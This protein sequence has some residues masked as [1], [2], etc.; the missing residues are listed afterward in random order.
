MP[1]KGGRTET[2]K[3]RLDPGTKKFRN[4]FLRPLA[5][6]GAEAALGFQVPGL[7]DAQQQALGGFA[8]LQGQLGGLLEQIQAQAGQQTPGLGFTP[9]QFDPASAQSFLNPF[10]NNAI[11]LASNERR[12]MDELRARQLAE[13]DGAF[14]GSRSAIFEA[15]AGRQAEIDRAGQLAGAQDRALQLGLTAFQGD[16][17]RAL[18]AAIANQ[19]GQ[20]AGRGQNLQGLGIG[21]QGL[22]LGGNLL[23]QQFGLGEIGR[24]VQQDQ[25]NAPI[26]GFEKAL[27]FGNAGIGPFGT[28]QTTQQSGG[29]LFQNLLGGV[30]IAAGGGLNPFAAISGLFGG[31]DPSGV[32]PL[33]GVF[34]S[35]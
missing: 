32:D 15:Q 27:Q 22:G 10:V 24:R 2:V 21:L 18:Q 6:Q 7:N 34:G 1:P 31:G 11:N 19:Q 25:L 26:A 33:S 16:Q 3:T 23:G 13:A 12:S 28:T 8:G 5:Q 4:Q 20:I 30:Q 14:G 35:F 17:N 29:S 9:G